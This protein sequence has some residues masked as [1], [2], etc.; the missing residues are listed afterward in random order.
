[1]AK[2]KD[3]KKRS[4]ASAARKRAEQHKSGFEMTSLSLPEGVDLF[5]LKNDKAVRVDILPYE[6]TESNEFADVGELHYERT[7]WVHRGIGAEQNSY[8]CLRKTRG[9]RCPICE[10]RAK[11]MKDPDADENLIKDLAPKERQ[12][13]NVIDT[14]DRD[15]GVQIWDISFHLFGKKLDACI[16]NADEDDGYERFADLE[17][18]F[19]L[20]LGIEQKHFAGIAYYEVESIDF[21]N[22]KENYDEDIL[23][24]SHNLDKILK[25]TPYEEL[26]SILLQ[27]EDDDT[28]SKKKDKGKTKSSKSKKQSE[29]EDD[30]EDVEDEVEDEVE[31]V[32]DEESAPEKKNKDKSK[33]SK[34]KKKDED[35][36]DEFGDFDFADEEEPNNDSEDEEEEP[37]EDVELSDLDEDND[38]E[39]F[40]TFEDE[41][42]LRCK[43]AG[44]DSG[45]YDTWKEAEL[46]VRKKKTK[47]SKKKSK[48]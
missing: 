20:K 7:Y 28:S 37:S 31:D 36:D 32:E 39:D 18:G 29:E 46:A 27:M 41:I 4:M 1:M 5:S 26:K 12:L 24:E 22:R 17:D 30:F 34:S 15:K 11:L 48:K 13:F 14:M 25:I 23:E 16:R 43:K 45:D 6:L 47:K 9:E 33:S 40:E 8:V 35:E 2:R 19:T 21:K 10:Y 42:S 3:R 44:L 38:D